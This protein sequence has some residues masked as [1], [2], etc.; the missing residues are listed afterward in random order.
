M[1][2]ARRIS[3]GPLLTVCVLCLA[4]IA[5]TPLVRQHLAPP[6]QSQTLY[7]FGTLLEVVIYGEDA[8]TAQAATAAIG[9]QLQ[10]YHHAW[11][12]WRPGE[13]SALNAAIARGEELTV[14]ADLAE[15]L[16]DAQ[17][18][19][20]ASEGLF[21]PAIGRLIALWG[22]HSDTAPTG[23]PPSASAI[24]TLLTARPR[25]ADLQIDGRRVSSVNPAI[26]L[27]LGAFAKGAALKRAADTLTRLGIQDA[28]LNA[29]GDV[30][31]LGRQGARP[32]R[33]AVRDPFGWDAV[34]ALSVQPGEAVFTSGNYERFLEHDGIRFSHILDPRTGLPVEQIV[35]ATVLHTDAGLA[36]A[37]A[38]A[39][40]VAGPKN[41]TAIAEAMG[42]QAALLIDQ[43]G[44]LHATPA[45][46][47]RL[48]HPTGAA[49][50]I[51]QGTAKL[52]GIRRHCNISL[53]VSRQLA[54]V[55]Q[56]S[57]PIRVPR[58]ADC[59]GRAAAPNCK[60]QEVENA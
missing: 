20:I 35:S 23:P 31:V 39:L 46:A 57:H 26:Q 8:A 16:Q 47:A 30:L 42:I 45:M 22:F 13:L 55:K 10:T 43:T 29:G 19:S 34:A 54:P 1:R 21:Q 36:D 59:S 18:I 49:L 28:V 37:A 60:C 53:S 44:Q 17:R 51:A 6:V 50:E 56:Q 52:G 7:V 2:R 5:A 58:R 25:I 41:W 24:A 15:M 32:W 12:G 48:Q 11:H 3:R 38:T 27:D 14:S 9:Q 40:S 4:A 33:V